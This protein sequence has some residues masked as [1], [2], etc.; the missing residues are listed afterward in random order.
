MI[1]TELKALRDKLGLSQTE[2]AAIISISQ[3]TWQRWE[4]S[5][6]EIPSAMDKLVRLTLAKRKPRR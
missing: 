4:I 1:G 5:S 2:A 6:K 3:R